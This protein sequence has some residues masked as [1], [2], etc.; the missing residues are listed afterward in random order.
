MHRNVGHLG[1]QYHRLKFSLFVMGYFHRLHFASVLLLSTMILVSCGIETRPSV[2][3]RSARVL[4]H[5]YDDGGDG[6]VSIQISLSDQIAEF[7]R[8]DREIGWCYVATGKEGHDTVPGTYKITEKVLDKHSN[9]YGWFEDEFGNVT[10]PDAQAKQKVPVGMVYVPAPMPC[11]MR[12]TSYGVGMH[13]GIIPEPGAPAS[14]G[15]I[16]LPREFVQS[17]FDVVVVGTPVVISNE[18]SNRANFATDLPVQ[19][20]NMRPIREIGDGSAQSVTYRDGVPVSY[21]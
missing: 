14:H 3:R 4:H 20:P 2:S 12:L 6:K 13:G 21:Q 7:K 8:G 5:W 9:I 15:C 17:L 19:Q 16:R 11:W 1:S 10:D 18:P